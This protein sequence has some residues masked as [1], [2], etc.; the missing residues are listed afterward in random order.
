MNPLQWLEENFGAREIKM[1]PGQELQYTPSATDKK[2]RAVEDA[3]GS[4]VPDFM[5]DFGKEQEKKG[6]AEALLP[7]AVMNAPGLGGLLPRVVAGGATEA[8]VPRV[9]P[10]ATVKTSPAQKD[11]PLPSTY[12]TMGV[13]YDSA[14]GQ[15]LNPDT[16]KSSSGGYSINPDG[17]AR[18]D[19]GSGDARGVDTSTAQRESL[20]T[21]PEDERMTAWA[22]ANPELAQKVLNKKTKQAGRG[23]IEKEILGRGATETDMASYDKDETFLPS[24]IPM[25]DRNMTKGFGDRKGSTKARTGT[26]PDQE[27]QNLLNQYMSDVKGQFADLAAPSAVQNPIPSGGDGTAID[28]QLELS[29]KAGALVPDM[30]NPYKQYR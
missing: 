12:T 1:A 18:T 22:K 3:I 8:I 23:A 13:E 2:L 24:E 26:T 16:K 30:A 7:G 27:S 17:G 10:G 4:V 29:K 6:F 20:R 11:K 9:I 14:T 25:A 19:Y 5:K 21:A 15:A 28:S